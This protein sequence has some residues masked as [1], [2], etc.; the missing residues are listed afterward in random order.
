MA[1]NEILSVVKERLGKL[2]VDIEDVDN[3]IL[4][5]LTKIET[6]ISSRFAEQEKA[7]DT[8]RNNAININ[9]IAKT[10]AISNKTV[11][12]YDLLSD[13]IR[14]CE[15]EYNRRL[16]GD[17]DKIARLKSRLDEAESTI[18]LFDENA[19]NAEILQHQI[20]L[21]NQEIADLNTK[22]EIASSA[23]P[24]TQEDDT[25]ETKS[26]DDK[27]L[28]FNPDRQKENTQN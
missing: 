16:P 10:G 28:Y 11:Y 14:S 5:H 23:T 7:L 12:K 20:E 17:K 27:I 9:T 24:H 26:Q 21:L 18:R 22:L 6:E 3:S 4:K 19:V 25:Q 13:Y 15:A 1:D 2:G 8:L